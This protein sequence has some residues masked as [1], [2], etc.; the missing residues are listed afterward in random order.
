MEIV[1]SD[2]YPVS[3]DWGFPFIDDVIF[4]IAHDEDLWS[5]SDISSHSLRKT[6]N[7][8]AILI[9]INPIKGDIWYSNK[10]LG[11]CDHNVNEW[12]LNPKEQDFIIRHRPD[13][14]GEI[15]NLAKELQEKYK[16]ELDLAGIEI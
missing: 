16:D 15:K 12:D 3:D 4:Y 9:C 14:I 6:L 8:N 11:I 7:H 13:L 1:V 5:A 2:N 10:D